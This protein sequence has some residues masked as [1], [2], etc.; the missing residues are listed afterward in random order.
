MPQIEKQNLKNYKHH[1]LISVGINTDTLKVYI[2]TFYEFSDEQM[3]EHIMSSILFNLN[4]EKYGQL[5]HTKDREQKMAHDVFIGSINILLRNCIKN[6]INKVEQI[7]K[8]YTESKENTLFRNK[9]QK[10]AIFHIYSIIS[11][12]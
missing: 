1:Y 2:D 10:L 3:Q 5:I 9:L 11:R 7:A 8:K 6:N 12:K 4:E